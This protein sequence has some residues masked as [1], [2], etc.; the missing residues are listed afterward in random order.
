MATIAEQLTSLAN[1]KTAIK[2]AIVAKGVAVADTDP[3]SAY[4]AKIGEISGGGAPATKFGATIECVF[5]DV[6]ADGNLQYPTEEFVFDGT[7]IK[8]INNNMFYYKFQYC[9]CTYVN[10]KDLVTVN[11]NGMY[12]SFH[13]NKI[14]G[15]D[16]G[17]LTTVGSYGFYRAFQNNLITR[18]DLGNLTTVGTAGFSNAFNDNKIEHVNLSNLTTVESI[19][20]QTFLGGNTP[21]SGRI[22][23]YL[24]ADG[25]GWASDAMKT[26]LS[27]LRDT[28]IHFSAHSEEWVSAQET[29][30]N[31]FGAAVSCTIYFDL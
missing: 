2:D 15:V 26:M 28:E 20:L 13:S 18:V 11:G 6:D 16:L 8:L 25:S 4:P 23:I 7:G 9:A 30:E 22:D 17:N 29:Y 24:P 19:G 1:T 5:G 12:Y 31:R 14:T 27:Q 3:F 10:L 21:D